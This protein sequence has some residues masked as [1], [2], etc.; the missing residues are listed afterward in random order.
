MDIHITKRK[1]EI[2]LQVKELSINAYILY[3]SLLDHHIKYSIGWKEGK[4][5]FKPED[6]IFIN[7]K[8]VKDVA[9]IRRYQKQTRAVDRQRERL[10][11]AK[12]RLKRARD[13]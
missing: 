1:S 7:W 8:N 4:I 10:E 3:F 6:R 9:K 2:K 13:S 5:N 12:D 11:D